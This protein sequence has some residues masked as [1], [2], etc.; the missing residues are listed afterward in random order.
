MSFRRDPHG[1]CAALPGHALHLRRTAVEPCDLAYHVQPQPGTL[2]A[3]AGRVHL[4]EA[5]PYLLLLVR[6]DALA[7]IPDS[8]ADNIPLFFPVN[9][10]ASL[11]RVRRRCRT[12]RRW[13]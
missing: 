1:E 3:A 5:L 6:R 12:G 13:K 7:V 8:Q 2:A 10:N 11:G 9:V 4:I